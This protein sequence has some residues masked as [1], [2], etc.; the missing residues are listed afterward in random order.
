MKAS[1]ARLDEPLSEA[2]RVA[3]SERETL[4]ARAKALAADTRNR[5]VIT[6]VRELQT[7]WQAHAKTLPLMRQMENALWV[8]FKAATDAVFTQR[9]AMHAE[10]DAGF[11]ANQAARETLIARLAGMGA[12]TAATELNRTLGEVDSAWRKCGDAPRSEAAK[13]DAQFRAAREATQ[14]FLAGSAQR[15]WQRICDTLGTK[16]ALC[17]EAESAVAPADLAARW[18][19]LPTLPAVWE[20]ALSGRFGEAQNGDAES[21]DTD[22]A[23]EAIATQLLQLESAL[24]IESPPAFHAARRELKLRAMKAAIEARQ[25]AAI[26]NADIERWF[27]GAIA[28]ANADAVSNERITTILA[29]LRNKPLR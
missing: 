1:V 11:K 7:E 22:E 2:R 15:G 14:Q 20:K 19:S 26:T 27:G 13:L 29:A 9:D 5:D 3:Q 10:R 6:R 12:D 4:I 28:Q 17:A 24:D 8:Q 18:A 25:S 21:T 23:A 16:L